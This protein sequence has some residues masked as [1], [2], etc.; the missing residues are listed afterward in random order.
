MNWPE[1]SLSLRRSAPSS[2]LRGYRGPISAGTTTVYVRHGTHSEQAERFTEEVAEARQ[3]EERLEYAARAGG[4]LALTVSSRFARHAESELMRRFDLERLSCDAMLLGTMKAQ[5]AAL[6]VEW[7]TVLAADATQ[8]GSRDWTNLTRLVQRAVPE[9]RKQ[10][11]AKSKTVL[12]LHPG[13]LARYQLMQLL[14]DL[15]DNAGRP[16]SLPGLWL[17]VPMSANGLPMIDGVSVPVISSA[18]WARVPQGWIENVHR[19]GTSAF[20]RDASTTNH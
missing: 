6:G 2:R 1:A 4:F 8:S 9:V 14:E 15:R 10:I 7:Q 16:G 17:L 11:M 5:A 3:F 13:L 12:L 18:Q 20:D 19:A